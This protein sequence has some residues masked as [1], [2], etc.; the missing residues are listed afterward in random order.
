[1]PT[2]PPLIDCLISSFICNSVFLCFSLLIC[3]M[4]I[5]NL[6]AIY[7]SLAIHYTLDDLPTHFIVNNNPVSPSA[8]LYHDSHSFCNSTNPL[9]QLF[10]SVPLWFCYTFPLWLSQPFRVFSAHTHTQAPTFLSQ[11]SHIVFLL[12]SSV[13]TCIFYTCIPPTT[14]HSLRMVLSDP[15]C[16]TGKFLLLVLLQHS[17]IF[18]I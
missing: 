16:G 4:H 7:T 5:Q 2:P 8:A 3:H 14:C 15:V 9:A 17:V 10:S 6:S 11:W 13:D 12:P 18:I 1:M